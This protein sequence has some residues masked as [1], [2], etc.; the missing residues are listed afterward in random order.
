MPP[1]NQLC[2]LALAGAIVLPLPAFAADVTVQIRLASADALEVSYE[3]PERCNRLAFQETSAS[4]RAFRASWQAVGDCGKVDGD[5]LGAS[6]RTVRFRVPASTENLGGYP[7]AFPM[8]EGIWLHT[9]K[10]AVAESCGKVGYRLLAPGSIAFGGQLHHAAVASAAPSAADA[11]ALLLPLELPASDGPLMYFSP[12]LNGATVARI[13]EV[14]RDSVAFFSAAM[15][16]AR[17]RPN[18]LTATSVTAAGGVRYEGDADDI[19]RL[20]FFN[21]PAGLDQKRQRDVTR[22]VSHEMS[23]RFQLRD[24]IGAYPNARL[25]HEGGAEFMRWMLA[26]RKGWLTP[27][28]AAA[29]LDDAL[30]ECLLGTGTRSWTD[31]PPREIGQRRLE[32]RCGLP[33]YVYGLAARQGKGTALARID[34]FYQQVRNG[35][36]PDFALALECGDS[37]GCAPRWLPRLLGAGASMASEW[38]RFLELSQ[39][40]RPVAPSSAQRDVMMLKAFGQLMTSDCGTNSAF[41]TAEGV[42]VDDIQT[43]KTLR[44]KMHITRIEGLPMFGNADALPALVAACSDGG[45]LR[46]GTQSGQLLTMACSQPAYRPARVFYAGDIERIIASLESVR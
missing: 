43:C 41:P 39:L 42:I 20:A 33:A 19:L 24:E 25:I 45:T 40:A 13:K 15:P 2:R 4:Y 18:V 5:A 32:Y 1:F 30:A 36:A 28:E 22:F 34:R 16:L 27:A 11:S 9:A 46:L 44:P 38:T 35:A 23:H 7:G 14:A 10:Y 29:E 8:G 3:L 37:P 31:M 6:C 26:I 12:T 17:F 21:W